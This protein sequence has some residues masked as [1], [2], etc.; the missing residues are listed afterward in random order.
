[1]TTPGLLVGIGMHRAAI[2]Y[3]FFYKPT[4]YIKK[5][6]MARSGAVCLRKSSTKSRASSKLRRMG[7]SALASGFERFNPFRLAEM[8]E[9]KKKYG[10]NPGGEALKRAL[11]RA[12]V[13]YH[14]CYTKSGKRKSR[15]SFS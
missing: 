15:A 3:A 6:E 13:K 10:R 9:Y 14:K 5:H 1:M 4:R 11:K 7:H 12:S 8:R 2:L